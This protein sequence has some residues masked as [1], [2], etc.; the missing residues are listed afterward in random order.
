MVMLS[1]LA[2][3]G[4]GAAHPL[5]GAVWAKY[6]SGQNEFTAN[7]S[8]N[9]AAA[10]FAGAVSHFAYD[11]YG[12]FEPRAGTWELAYFS[13]EGIVGAYFLFPLWKKEP[14][15]FWG[16]VGAM[17]PDIE[18]TINI[19]DKRKFPTHNGMVPHGE[20]ENFCQGALENLVMNSFSYYL[21]TQ[22]S[23]NIGRYQF[24]MNINIWNGH[25]IVD[26]GIHHTVYKTVSPVSAGIAL[27]F[28]LRHNRFFEF[29]STTWMK[30][31]P[32]ISGL[33]YP[34]RKMVQSYYLSY[35]RKLSTRGIE[36]FVGLGC[37]VFLW[38]DSNPVNK[39]DVSFVTYQKSE[40]RLVMSG[41]ID[42]DL[43]R[44]TTIV[45]SYRFQSPSLG[46]TSARVSPVAEWTPGLAVLQNFF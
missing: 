22:D 10:F 34:I 42:F 12:N 44:N 8:S 27:R 20:R 3:P 4:N 46:Y 32:D 18:H 45:I 14:A 39:G 9:Y 35:N 38:G 21:L 1:K 2:F 16:S 29:Y 43:N 6:F 17:V 19:F 28:H 11:V 24:G 37:G 30:R 7:K 33:D 26:D 40:Y 13:V 41:G 5:T 23:K 36:P 25:N 15:L 31:A